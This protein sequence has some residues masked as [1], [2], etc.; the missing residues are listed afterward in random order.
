[1][2]AIA[3]SSV[4]L[5]APLGP[6]IA[7]SSPAD[8]RERHGVEERQLASVADPDPPGQLVHVDADAP[9]ATLAAGVTVASVVPSNVARSS[10]CEHRSSFLL[11]SSALASDR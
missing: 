3:S 6:T 5:P 1:M 10:C 11:G 7:T 9:G 4:V 8:D 2:P